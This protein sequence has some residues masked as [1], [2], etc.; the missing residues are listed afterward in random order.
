MRRWLRIF[1]TFQLVALA[2]IFF[3]ANSA[4]DAFEILATIATRPGEFFFPR[5]IVNGLVCLAILLGV[6][7]WTQP[8]YFDEWLAE[9]RP[10]AQLVVATVVL[11]ALVLLGQQRGAQFIYFQ[12]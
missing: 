1:V 2:W 10:A 8:R 9:R 5:E 11:F 3:R 4:S 6:E 12:F 7:A